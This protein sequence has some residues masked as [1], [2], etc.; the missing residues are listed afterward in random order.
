MRS[1]VTLWHDLVEELQPDLL[2][3]SIR[4]AYLSHIRF[5]QITPWETIFTVE[6]LNP[7]HIDLA[8]FSL[9]SG[10][11]MISIFGRAAELP[12]GTVSNTDKLMLGEF[13]RRYVE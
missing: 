6:R 9:S 12:F 8:R 13:L 11:R 5:R 7:Y 3:I 2:I 1:G 4:R 10:K